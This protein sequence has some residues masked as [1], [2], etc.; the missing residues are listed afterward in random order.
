MRRINEDYKYIPIV[1][2]ISFSIKKCI[3]WQEIKDCIQYHH[4]IAKYIHPCEPP[5]ILD[6]YYPDNENKKPTV[7]VFIIFKE[8]GQYNYNPTKDQIEKIITSIKTILSK[9]FDAIID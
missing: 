3:T 4:E 6:I 7:R 1:R 2:D 5:S 9:R 8:D